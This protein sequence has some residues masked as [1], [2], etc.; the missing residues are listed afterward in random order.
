MPECMNSIVP[1]LVKNKSIAIEFDT[2]L[3]SRVLSLQ[4]GKAEALG[5]FE[6]SHYLL[7]GTGVVDDFY[8]SSAESEEINDKYGHGVQC[9][10]AGN[11]GDIRKLLRLCVYDN[12]PSTIFIK[13]QYL[14]TG[15]KDIDIVGWVSS[16]YTIDSTEE[17]AEKLFWSFQGASFESRPDWVL[18]LGNGFSRDNF[19][20]MND[21][22]YGGGIPVTDIW[23][24]DVGLAV[25]HC[26]S[27]PKL[28]SLPVEVSGGK[29]A[30]SVSSDT[31]VRLAPGEKLDT[32]ETFVMVHQG[33]F[34]SMMAEYRRILEAG[35]MTFAPINHEAYETTWCAWGYER[36]FKI[37]QI[38]GALPKI[39]ELGFK[40]IC[41]DDGW[42]YEEGDFELSKEKFPDGEEGIKEFVRRIHE[43]GLKVQLWWIPM[44][45]DPKSLY[46]RDHHDSVILDVN[47]KEQ[48]VSWWDNYYLCPACD[49]VKEHTRK[50]VRKILEDWDFDG[51]KI[52]GQH[53]NAAP[54]CYNEAHHHERPEESYEAVPEFFR[55]I[56]EEA[57]QIKPDALIMFCPCGTCCS[58]YTMPYFDMP[59]ASDPLSSWQVRSRGKVFKA[60]MGNRIP[61]NGDHVELSDEG[62]DF[63]S[64]VGTGGVINTKFTWPVGS[65]PV[66]VVST[67]A[68]YDLTP[69]REALWRKWMNI[70]N[71]KKL[72]SGEYIG[73]LYTLGYDVPECHV[74][75]QSGKMYYSFF[76]DHFCGEVE[77]RG[78]DEKS[79]T[80]YDY[81][82]E[83]VIA[84]LGP[85][86]NKINIDFKKH[87]LLEVSEA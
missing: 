74:I 75:K 54:L 20:G 82:N 80:V 42:Q 68:N 29:A 64:T 48:I 27:V 71:D 21:P 19:M 46:C 35:G 22:D 41:L 37:S 85:G 6:S 56:Y 69:E 9:T 16:R 49:D 65:G 87:A 28:V 61:Y 81:V 57:K 1:F 72:S 33:D 39:K 15:D 67:G 5:N 53:L 86:E 11:A 36:G 4:T 30:F 73:D 38:Y 18:P 8:I 24:R 50:T 12:F 23:R 60:L 14:N 55:L 47:G 2:C 13:T 26:E 66:S 62:C 76:A 70:Y 63:A 84:R 32:V 43:Q 34:F 52:D 10:I 78:L 17:D 51:I 79:H 83:K 40:W 58:V 25:G 31:K 7:T 77:L 3:R 44:A 45:C 59:V